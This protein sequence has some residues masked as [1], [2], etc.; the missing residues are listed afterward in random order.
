MKVYYYFWKN[1]P[2]RAAW[3]GRAV[4]LVCQCKPMNS[5]LIEDIETGRCLVTSL[6][7]IRRTRPKKARG[8]D[9]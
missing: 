8:K 3:H 4:R 9:D 5:I 7:A 6:N 2:V 1:N